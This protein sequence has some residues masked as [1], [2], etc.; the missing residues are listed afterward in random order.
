MLSGQV[1]CLRGVLNEDGLAVSPDNPCLAMLV[2]TIE[3]P[4]PR[5]LEIVTF[6]IELPYWLTDEFIAPRSKHRLGCRIAFKA[7]PLIVENQNAIKRAVKDGLVLA[8]G[9][10]K[11][12]SR[13]SV[14]ATG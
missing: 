3:K 6:P 1:I 14:F 13:L 2:L 8:L 9:G 12:A 11:R 10:I 5:A 4:S 7:D